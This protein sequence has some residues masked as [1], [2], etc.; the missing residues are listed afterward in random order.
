MIP[1]PFTYVRAGSV[2]EAVSL[3]VEHGDEAKLISGGHSLLPMMKLRLAFPTVLVDVSRLSEMSAVRVDGDELVIGG[4]VRHCDLEHSDLV[5]SEVPLIADVARHIGDRQVRHRGT[6]G[7]S[8]AHADPAADLPVAVSA[9]GGTIVLEGPQGRRNVP[10]DD[11]FVGYF[12]TAASSD[13]VLV[14]IRVPRTA[15]AG[16]G[17]QK[18]VRRANDWA[19]VGVAVHGDRIALS[20]MGSTPV[21]AVAAEEA[22]QQGQTPVEVGALA[23]D[24]SDP[25]TD[26]HADG[27]YRMHLARILTTRVLETASAR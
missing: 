6:I 24:G 26:M 11:F 8:L 18:F 25:I 22:L 19:I 13:E 27:E 10:V 12:E 23:G 21:R 17:Y 20:N 3:L 7:G 14:E 16:W 9:L 5:K 15:G 4:S 2:A 1:A